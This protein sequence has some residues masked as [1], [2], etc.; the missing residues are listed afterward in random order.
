MAFDWTH[1]L[2]I[3]REIMAVETSPA[4][5]EARWR[6]AISR[7]YYAAFNKARLYMEEVFQI[8]WTPD[9]GHGHIFVA[10]WFASFDDEAY[11]AIGQY[12]HRLR[13]R[14]RRADYEAKYGR[15]EEQAND[16]LRL[17]AEIIELL[18]TLIR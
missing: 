5:D 17:A 12:L 1:Y 13:G 10:D 2:N 18:K 15:L 16:S 4:N 11:R 9:E 14:R 6:A 3:A 7:A 8:R